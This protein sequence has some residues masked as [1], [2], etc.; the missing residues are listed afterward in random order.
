MF[1]ERLPSPAWADPYR[2]FGATKDRPLLWE[3]YPVPAN[4]QEVFRFQRAEPRQRPGEDTQFSVVPPKLPDKWTQYFPPT[5]VRHTQPSNNRTIARMLGTVEKQAGW[6]CREITRQG[7]GYIPAGGNGFC[8]SPVRPAFRF[9]GP[10]PHTAPKAVARIEA[11]VESRTV[12]SRLAPALITAATA[13]QSAANKSTRA[14]KCP[15]RPDESPM[16]KS[17]AANAGADSVRSDTSATQIGRFRSNPSCQCPLFL[18]TFVRH[19][20]VRSQ[21]FNGVWKHP[22]ALGLNHSRWE[23]TINH[24]FS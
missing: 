2:I 3:S 18:P 12:R 16:A 19:T 22:S 7:V 14:G 21:P 17:H 9:E 20:P 23:S 5:F 11:I 4:S 6:V 1:P 24:Q 10:N 15:L 13:L 8:R